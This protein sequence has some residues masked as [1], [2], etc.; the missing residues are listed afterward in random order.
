MGIS[1][2]VSPDLL[3]SQRITN[4]HAHV[5]LFFPIAMADFFLSKEGTWTTPPEYKIICDNL[6]FRQADVDTF[7]AA[8]HKRATQ[9]N[10]FQ[11]RCAK[12]HCPAQCMRK[13]QYL[14]IRK[15]FLICFRFFKITLL[16]PLRRKITSHQFV[17]L[18]AHHI[19]NKLLEI[20]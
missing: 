2:H 11:I 8:L 7:G 15:S 16:Q 17:Y 14:K 10:H 13:H 12:L 4:N 9:P 3:L 19:K 5:F 6:L 18:Y 1:F 20:L